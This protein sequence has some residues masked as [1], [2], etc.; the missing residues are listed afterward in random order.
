MSDDIAPHEAGQVVPEAAE[1]Y[2]SFFVPALFGQWPERV[3]DAAGVE[4]GDKVLDVGCGTGVLARAAARR[5]SAAGSVTGVDINDAMLAVARRSPEPVRWRNARA[6][7]LPF[8]DG[9]YHRV[10][11][12]FAAM[13]FADRGRATAE[14]ARVLRP[15]GRVAVANWAPVE[16]S[17]GYAAMTELLHRLIGPDAADALRA[18]FALGSAEQLA[19][20]LTPYLKDVAVD[21]HDGKARFDSVEAWVH[22]DIRGWTLADM[23][24]N[25]QYDELL[26]AARIELQDFVGADGRV[27]FPAPALIATG[28]AVPS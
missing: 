9:S 6:E 28:S 25:T 17:P 19:A 23:I 3:L 20:M 8:P 16:E 15:G 18:P 26:Q 2:E 11:S 7:K 13:F 22:T 24:D 1:T 10:V 27:R 12:Q 21:R 5:L 4:A 14:M